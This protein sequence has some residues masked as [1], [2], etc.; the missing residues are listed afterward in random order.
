MSSDESRASHAEHGKQWGPGADGAARLRKARFCDRAKSLWD[1]GRRSVRKIL[2]VAARSSATARGAA[3]PRPR[4][5]G[6]PGRA[7]GSRG[8]AGACVSPNAYLNAQDGPPSRDV[9]TRC[10]CDARARRHRTHARNGNESHLKPGH[11]RPRSDFPRWRRWVAVTTAAPLFDAF[12]G[13]LRRGRRRARFDGF[14]GRPAHTTPRIS[15][16]R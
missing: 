14:Y 9:S 6:S 10:L 8:W 4:V 15:W 2:R 12:G 1:I 16:S 13:A 11:E 5:A 3:A 7:G